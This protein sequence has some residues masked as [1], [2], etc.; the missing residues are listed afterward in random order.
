MSTHARHLD[1][2][3]PERVRVMLATG[4]IKDGKTTLR[5]A[6]RADRHRRL[7]DHLR[8]TIAWWTRINYRLLRDEGLSRTLA[9]SIVRTYAHMA[10]LGMGECSDSYRQEGGG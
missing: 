6:P 7:P 3:N 1:S 5:V 4:H 8:E 2:T 9:R 10:S